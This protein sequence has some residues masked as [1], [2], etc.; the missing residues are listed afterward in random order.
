MVLPHGDMFE[1]SKLD[2]GVQETAEE[3]P[4]YWVDNEEP[5]EDP[6]E[7]KVLRK[8]L[9]NETGLIAL[10]HGSFEQGLNV[11]TGETWVSIG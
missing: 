8:P 2:V 4:V 9:Q 7:G 5:N 11:D 10:R 1:P 3:D 6:Y